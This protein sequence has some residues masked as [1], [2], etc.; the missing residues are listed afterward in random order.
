MPEELG[1][2][3]VQGLRRHCRAVDEAG[4]ALE[5]D[6]G[7]LVA[8]EVERD[9]QHDPAAGKHADWRTS[10]AEERGRGNGGDDTGAT[11][12]GLVFDAPLVGPHFDCG[13]VTADDEVDDR[14]GRGRGTERT[15]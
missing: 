12:E 11:R 10:L 15:E 9:L 8:V 5:S 2:E 3:A 4:V 1:V 6:V 14:A 13:P 7:Q